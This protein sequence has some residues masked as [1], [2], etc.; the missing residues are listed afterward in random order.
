LRTVLQPLHRINRIGSPYISRRLAS[1]P[2]VSDVLGVVAEAVAQALLLR[3][4]RIGEIVPP[5]LAGQFEVSAC[6]ADSTLH[7]PLM[8]HPFAVR[9]GQTPFLPCTTAQVV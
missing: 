3:P 1:F 2:Q 5:A 8:I 7:L 6:Q 9:F 4:H